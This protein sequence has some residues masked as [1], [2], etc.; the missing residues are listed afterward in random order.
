[1]GKRPLRTALSPRSLIRMRPLV[2]VQPGPKNPP[3]TS[4]NARRFDSR[5][6]PDWRHPA[7]VRSRW[8]ARDGRPHSDIRTHPGALGSS[9]RLETMHVGD[10]T[11][12]G[13]AGQ[14]RIQVTTPLLG[15]PR[16][17]GSA[18]QSQIQ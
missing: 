1:P 12:G 17:Y 5:Y 8:H 11:G 18:T 15:P 4:G 16:N 14:A 3:L 10:Q 6:Q 9:V 7:A 13:K 2:Q